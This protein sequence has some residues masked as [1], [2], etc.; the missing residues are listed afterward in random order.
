MAEMIVAEELLK[1]ISEE[2]PCGEDLSYDAGLQALETMVRGKPET[3]FSAAEPPDWKKLRSHCW[4]LFARSKDLRIVMILSVAALELDGLSGFRES[5]ALIRGLLEKYWSAVH[6]QL[7]PSDN[8]DPLQRMN[9]VA[10]MATPIGTFGDDFRII[11]RLRTAPLCNS[12]QMGRYSLADILR[13]ETGAP[14]EEGKSAPSLVHI[15]AA[16]RDSNQEE[17]LERYRILSDCVALVAGIDE[18]L[19]Q[20]VGPASAPDL[21]PLSAEL[22]SMQKRIAPY[23]PETTAPPDQEGTG[24]A[25]G[26][27]FGTVPAALSLTGEIRSRED[28]LRLLHKICKYYAQAEPSSPVPLVLKRAARLAEMDFMQIIKD[29]S[30]DAIGQI[31]RITGEAKE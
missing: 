24:A 6:P 22:A 23:V 1:P 25:R 2:A 21:T 17:S 26:T 28:V 29:M 18:F 16:F 9:I 27:S 8:N 4:E 30:P 20:T 14:A 31:Q 3:Q 12:A 10:S 13:A 19:T 15:D 7:D 11:E 5:L